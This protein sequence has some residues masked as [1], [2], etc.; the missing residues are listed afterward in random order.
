LNNFITVPSRGF[1]SALKPSF[2]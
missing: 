1:S 2:P